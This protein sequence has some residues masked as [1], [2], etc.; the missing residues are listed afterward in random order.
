MLSI[1]AFQIFHFALRCLFLHFRH[2][3]DAAFIFFD[4]AAMRRLIFLRSS[5]FRRFAR[6]H[7]SPMMLMPPCFD[8]YYY[9]P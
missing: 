7:F 3:A 6:C 1:F 8:G 9:A 4:I 2:A 5:F